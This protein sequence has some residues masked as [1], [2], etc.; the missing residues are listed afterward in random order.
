MRTD[1]GWIRWNY[2]FSL[3]QL[4]Q[5]DGARKEFSTIINGEKDPVLMLLSLYMLNSLKIDDIM[6]RAQ[7]DERINNF[8]KAN[9]RE[10]WYRKIEKAKGNIQV[11]ILSKIVKEASDWIYKQKPEA[12]SETVN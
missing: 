1:K 9:N 8:K 2:G 10:N 12:Q 11:L 4:R 7:M 3:L 5:F 6:L